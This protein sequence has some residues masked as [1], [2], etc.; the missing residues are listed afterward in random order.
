MQYYQALISVEQTA[1]ACRI[2]DALIAKQLMF[3]GPVVGGPPSS[4]GTSR[5]AKGREAHAEP[6]LVD[7]V[8]AL[9]FVP[10][11]DIP[12]RTKSSD[13]PVGGRR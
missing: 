9:T 6:E 3:G 8:V 4:C 5:I 13:G 2:L 1:Q 12:H 11:A 10:K 7:A